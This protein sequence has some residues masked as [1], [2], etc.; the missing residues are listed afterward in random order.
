MEAVQ[1]DVQDDPPL[2][3][4]RDQWYDVHTAEIRFNKYNISMQI[5]LSILIS[6]AIV[7][8]CLGGTIVAFPTFSD[9]PIPPRPVFPAVYEFMMGHHKQAGN[10]SAIHQHF[11]SSPLYDHYLTNLIVGFTGDYC[12]AERKLFIRT[13][14]PEEQV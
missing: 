9:I 2:G 4:R 11:S 6:V 7:L 14:L 1:E 3:T 8:P 12:D 5:S 10:E 13:P